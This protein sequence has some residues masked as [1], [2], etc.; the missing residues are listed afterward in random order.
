MT[1]CSKYSMFPKTSQ[2]HGTP[3]LIFSYRWHLKWYY[4]KSMSNEHESACLCMLE[5]KKKL[6]KV[7][8]SRKKFFRLP[9]FLRK[10]NCSLNHLPMKMNKDDSQNNHATPSDLWPR[11]GQVLVNKTIV[12]PMANTQQNDAFELSHNFNQKEMSM[13]PGT[14]SKVSP[15]KSFYLRVHAN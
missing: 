12:T 7:F 2:Q 6:K 9:H 11:F 3:N 10:C 5:Q 4:P 15:F 14:Q 13:L 8:D 1:P